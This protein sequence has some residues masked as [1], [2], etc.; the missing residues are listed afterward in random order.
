MTKQSHYSYKFTDGMC[1]SVILVQNK[2]HS[3]PKYSIQ[4][5]TH[6]TLCAHVRDTYALRYNLKRLLF[7][8]SSS[9]IAVFSLV[10]GLWQKAQNIIVSKSNIWTPWWPPY[11]RSTDNPTNR[12][13][14]TV[15]FGRTKSIIILLKKSPHVEYFQSM[16]KQRSLNVL[17]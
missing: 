17:R 3:Y 2:L 13:S 5:L 14:I 12:R 16:A 9:S 10:L 15:S 7:F 8:L 1:D 11:R 6:S 4:W